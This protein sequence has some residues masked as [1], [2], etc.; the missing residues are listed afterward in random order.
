[1]ITEEVRYVRI[2]WAMGSSLVHIKVHVD[3]KYAEKFTESEW[4]AMSEVVEGHMRTI[5]DFL[6]RVIWTDQ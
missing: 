1:M 2:G 6:S 5:Y 4:L 3:S